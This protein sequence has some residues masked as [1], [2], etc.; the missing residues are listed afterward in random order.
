MKKLIL[1]I[2]AALATSCVCPD[3]AEKA[4]FDV[5]YPAH[6]EYVLGDENLSEEDRERRIRL[7]ESWKAKVNAEQ[8]NGCESIFADIFRG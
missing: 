6:K 7:L 1:C 5:L 2:T 8:E 3:E 4:T